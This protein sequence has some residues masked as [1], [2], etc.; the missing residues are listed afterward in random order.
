MGRIH[1]DKLTIR[2]K[3]LTAEQTRQGV[4]GLGE[5]VLQQLAEKVT[6]PA[7]MDHVQAGTV[8]VGNQA[9]STGWRQQAIHQI[10]HTVHRQAGKT[11]KTR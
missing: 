2:V 8:H 11:E 9:G 5:A 7:T 6:G 3:G 1:I 4:Q 10:V